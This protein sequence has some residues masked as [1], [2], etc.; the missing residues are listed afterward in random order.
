MLNCFRP[1]LF[2]ATLIAVQNLTCGAD[3]RATGTVHDFELKVSLGERRFSCRGVITIQPLSRDLPRLNARIT[4]DCNA[5]GGAVLRLELSE[6][7]IF[8]F[9][10]FEEPA[11]VALSYYDESGVQQWAESSQGGS[12]SWGTIT[13]FA[14]PVPAELR[15]ECVHRVRDASVQSGAGTRT[16]APDGGLEP[17]PEQFDRVEVRRVRWQEDDANAYRGEPCPNGLQLVGAEV[18]PDQNVAAFEHGNEDL[19]E[20]GQE[21]SAVGRGLDGRHGH[22]AF[23]R[24]RTDHRRDPP[25]IAG[26]G[27]V[28]LL[29]LDG[30]AID[31]GHRQ[32]RAGLIQKD[33]ASSWRPALESF[34]CFAER[35]DPLGIALGRDD[36]LFFSV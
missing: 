15:W 20:K 23:G 22:D 11:D 24:H 10:H 5:G 16:H 28:D 7:E 1:S 25:S 14:K 26:N 31:A 19:V 9:L 35:L 34:V 6:G 29:P 36:G 8:D 12:G 32:G 30:S 13:A 18:V 17:C 27:I 4:V 21:D 33:Q 3:A 2:V